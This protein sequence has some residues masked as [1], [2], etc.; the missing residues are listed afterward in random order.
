MNSAS[1]S[2]G[3][4]SRRAATRLLGFGAAA[5]LMPGLQSHAAETT[6]RLPVLTR[7]IPSTGEKLPVIGLGT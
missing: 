2:D 4:M 5:A 6:A 1:E 7:P 3:A